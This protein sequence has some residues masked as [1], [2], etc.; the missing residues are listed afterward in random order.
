MNVSVNTV[1]NISTFTIEGR[2]DTLTAPEL[3]KAFT[4]AEPVSDKVIFDMSGVDYISSAGMRVIIAVH[5]AMTKKNGLV[6]KG[7]SKNVRTIINLTGFTKILN[8]EE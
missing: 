7:L 8:I 3:E 1:D 5:R 4:E 2:I 6:L